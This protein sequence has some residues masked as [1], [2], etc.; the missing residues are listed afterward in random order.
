M[1]GLLCLSLGQTDEATEGCFEADIRW[2]VGSILHLGEHGELACAVG[3]SCVGAFETAAPF[4]G[5]EEVAREPSEL[6]RNCFGGKEG[7]RR[8]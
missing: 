5:D 2:V 3:V 1:E 6:G 7:R 4:I 8:Q